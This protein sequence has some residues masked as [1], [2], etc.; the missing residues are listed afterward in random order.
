MHRRGHFRRPAYFLTARF[1]QR[2]GPHRNTEDGRITIQIP[3]KFKRR[4]GRKEI[5]LPN[6]EGKEASAVQE[7]LVTSVA[8]AHRWL[9]LLEDGRFGSVSEL[10]EAIGLDPSL[11]R[12]HLNLTL[13][14]PDL[15]RQILGGNEP[16]G[17]AL[18]GLLQGV[19]VRWEEQGSLG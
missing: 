18:R 16:E 2:T 15:V 17:V 12:R 1:T 7:S 9:T 13:L 5:V 10:A 3:M 19:P 14:R 6:G 8:R 4:S 11:V